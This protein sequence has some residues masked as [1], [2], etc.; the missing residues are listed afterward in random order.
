MGGCA[1]RQDLRPKIGAPQTARPRSPEAD[2]RIEP[3]A[4]LGLLQ[5]GYGSR[6]S[7]PS[8][9]RA[10]DTPADR[11]MTGAQHHVAA[12]TAV[13]DHRW[14]LGDGLA[15]R[16]AH[17]SPVPVR[18]AIFDM[19]DLSDLSQVL[20]SGSLA[21]RHPAMEPPMRNSGHLADPRF[22]SAT[23][24]HSMVRPGHPGV[25]RLRRSAQERSWGR[26]ADAFR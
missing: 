23:R 15:V 1:R 26:K 16:S 19:A 21:P 20:D 11:R 25:R 10:I 18:F 6:P 3:T 2:I 13:P 24:C 4:R 8:G 5:R 12:G 7:D 9:K 22:A 14:N 17:R